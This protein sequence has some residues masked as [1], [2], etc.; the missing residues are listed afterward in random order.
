VLL[1]RVPEPEPPMPAMPQG[2]VRVMVDLHRRLGSRII[3]AWSTPRDSVLHTQAHLTWC[4]I[5]KR[6]KRR[7]TVART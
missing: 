5:Q 4:C 3:V 2:A 1:R 7:A 6:F